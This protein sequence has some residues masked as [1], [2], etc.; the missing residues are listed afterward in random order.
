[1][2]KEEIKK[3]AKAEKK[4]LLKILKDENVSDSKIQALNTYLDNAAW[5]KVQLEQAIEL[6]STT[7]IVIP[8]DNGGGQKGIRANPAFG[9]Y[10]SL[11]KTYNSTMSVIVDALPAESE[12]KKHTKAD[13]PKNALEM[14]KAKRTG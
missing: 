11:W 1:M 8:Y 4:R 2:T 12:A 10:E 14:V 9:E 7:Q 6:I 5:Q 13:L 3:A